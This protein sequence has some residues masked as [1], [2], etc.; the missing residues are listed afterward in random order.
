MSAFVLEQGTNAD[1]YLPPNLTRLHLD[2]DPDKIPG[3]LLRL[4]NVSREIVVVVG[5][6]VGQAVIS[7]IVHALEFGVSPLVMCNEVAVP[8]GV[9]PR[10][11]F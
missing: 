4:T 5:M 8:E 2:V 7:M 6:L 1:E 9:P 10:A 11:C 3:Q